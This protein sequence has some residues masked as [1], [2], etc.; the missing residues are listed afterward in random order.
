MAVTSWHKGKLLILWAWGVLL[1]G[2]ALTAFVTSPVDS[3]PTAHLFEL[4]FSI[5]VPLVLS[6]L[7]WRWLGA[8]EDAPGVRPK[9]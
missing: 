1:G 6:F 4:L 9:D 2:L 5:A 7:T 8:R 3:A